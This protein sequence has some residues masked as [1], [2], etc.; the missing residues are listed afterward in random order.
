MFSGSVP[1]S[2]N[3]GIRPDVPGGRVRQMPRRAL[4]N[5]SREGGDSN[6]EESKG[7]EEE[8]REEAVTS[9]IKAVGTGLLRRS[10]PVPDPHAPHQV[11]DGNPIHDI[12]SAHHM[13]EDGIP[14]VEVRL[15]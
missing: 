12:H 7:R 5:T 2:E 3:A 4:A 11:P 8:G 6:G 13:T 10:N 15:R 9:A 1:R 14:R